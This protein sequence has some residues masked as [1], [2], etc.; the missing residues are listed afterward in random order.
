MS[1]RKETSL[2]TGSSGFIGRY[3]VRRLAQAQGRVVC[4]YRHRL[5]EPHEN[6]LPFY[7]DLRSPDLL[8]APLKGVDTVVHL[9]WNGNF[10][11]PKEDII[12]DSRELRSI[13]TPNIRALRNLIHAMERAKTSRLIFLSVR[14]ADCEAGVSFLKEKYIAEHYILN[15]DIREK[16]IIRCP[17]IWSGAKKHDRFVK[18]VLRLMRLPGFSIMPNFRKQVCLTHVDDIVS[19]IVEICQDQLRAGN[20]I[21]EPPAQVTLNIRELFKMISLT[22]LCKNKLPIGG[23]LGNAMLPLLEREKTPKIR[24]FLALTE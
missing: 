24:Q 18:T 23:V 3:L 11:G 8:L 20:L 9:A 22:V 10:V 16:I 14:G 1:V 21:I 19:C 7:S 17:V 4:M 13:F 12:A 6:I 15:S 5:P 2:V